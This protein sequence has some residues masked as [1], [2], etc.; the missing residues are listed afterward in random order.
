MS[1]YYPTWLGII[2]NIVT[3]QFKMMADNPSKSKDIE[4][5]CK[6][7]EKWN[8]SKGAEVNHILFPLSW[9][10]RYGL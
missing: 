2:S 4:N 1:M 8:L 6:R 5:K 3:D 9:P 10:A 7:N